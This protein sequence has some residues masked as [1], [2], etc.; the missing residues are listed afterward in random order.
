MTSSRQRPNTTPSPLKTLILEHLIPHVYLSKQTNLLYFPSL[1]NKVTNNQHLSCN[2]YYNILHCNIMI[3]ITIHQQLLNNIT[4][5][6]VAINICIS[7][8]MLYYLAIIIGAIT[9]YLYT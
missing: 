5:Q 3:A 1:I 2:V 9:T 8:F 6:M 4:Q 7:R